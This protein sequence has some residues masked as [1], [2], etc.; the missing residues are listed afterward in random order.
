MRLFKGY[1]LKRALGGTNLVKRRRAWD[2][3]GVASTVGTIMALMIFMTLLS[4]FTNQYVPVWMEDNE[5]KHMSNVEAQFGNL[6]WAMDNQIL[7]AHN[8]GSLDIMIYS[9]V[10]LG[11]EGVPMFASPTIGFLN[12]LPNEGASNISFN[13]TVY[14]ANYTATLYAVSGNSSGAIEMVAPNRYYVQQTYIYQN[15]A[16]ILEQPDGQIVKSMP[17]FRIRQEGTFYRL[18][19]A[20][21]SLIG[22][23]KSY[24]GAGTT[25]IHTALR[26]TASD[27]YENAANISGYDA[28]DFTSNITYKI[29]SQ[30]AVAWEHFFTN[31]LNRTSVPYNAS[32]PTQNHSAS[33]AV[34]NLTCLDKNIT[35]TFDYRYLTSVTVTQAQFELIVGEEGG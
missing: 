1:A 20:Q 7:A 31:Y 5:A 26:Y 4:V 9:P 34:C 16:L 3:E 10:T 13:Y 14:S 6:K 12:I 35:F 27:Y 33:F 15:D 18:S 32:T 24:A 25:G 8:G 23:N 21:V 11:S 22:V 30:Q 19:V 2:S 17:Q 29:Y 28:S